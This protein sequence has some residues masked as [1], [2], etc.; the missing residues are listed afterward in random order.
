MAV[1]GIN[2]YFELSAVNGNV[3][4][5]EVQPEGYYEINGGREFRGVGPI[6]FGF[7]LPEWAS[8]SIAADLGKNEACVLRIGKGIS[9]EYREK[10][11]I[12]LAEKLAYL[13]GLDSGK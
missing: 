13:R 5:E 10:F 8:G 7:I 4:V 6:E 11:M 9:D 1:E 2:R 3:C 12:S